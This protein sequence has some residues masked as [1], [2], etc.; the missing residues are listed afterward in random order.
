MPRPIVSSFHWSRWLS[1]PNLSNGPISLRP[2]NPPCTKW[3]TMKAIQ[4]PIK[5]DS[6]VMCFHYFNIKINE[7]T[8]D[9]FVYHM[10][11]DTWHMINHQ[12][13]QIHLLPLYKHTAHVHL[14]TP[15]PIFMI[16]YWSLQILVSIIN[17]FYIIFF[18]ILWKLF[19]LNIIIL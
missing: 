17:T 5:G 8:N 18:F 9:I 13:Y 6:I 14:P 12:E 19:I 3:L 2:T 10:T 16:I 1:P 7:I 11:H 15:P 4:G